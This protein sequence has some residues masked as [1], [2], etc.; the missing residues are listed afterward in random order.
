[1][2][3]ADLDYYRIFTEE[4]SFDNV[5]AADI[6][7]ILLH[8][9]SSPLS[10]IKGYAELIVQAENSNQPLELANGTTSVSIQD[11]A[12]RVVRNAEI[13]RLI[14]DGVRDGFGKWYEQNNPK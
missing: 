10:S 14:L 13:V 11:C 3:P 6:L 9:L 5:S 2:E 8:E 4:F 1:M 7:G 12:Q